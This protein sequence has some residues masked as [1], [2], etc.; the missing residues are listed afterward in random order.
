MT[1]I[2]KEHALETESVKNEVFYRCER[3]TGANFGMSDNN[4]IISGLALVPYCDTQFD[5]VAEDVMNVGAEA[6]FLIPDTLIDG[7][8]YRATMT[9]ISRD[10]ET[11]H[12]EDW[13]VQFDLV[14]DPVEL[15]RIEAL[16]VEMVAENADPEEEM[17]S[18]SVVNPN[19]E[20]IARVDEDKVYTGT[21]SSLT[22]E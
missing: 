20:S 9:N 18:F 12:V 22:S 21:I 10:W 11:G 1:D 6:S 3:P 13:S 5:F 19:S 17:V 8:V 7:G 15:E 4:Q 14:T 16:R 2:F